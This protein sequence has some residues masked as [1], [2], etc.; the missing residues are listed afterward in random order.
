MS[1]RHCRLKTKCNFYCVVVVLENNARRPER[2]SH[3]LVHIKTSGILF[4]VDKKPSVCLIYPIQRHWRFLNYCRNHVKAINAKTISMIHQNH[5]IS[6][7][8]SHL[9]HKYLSLHLCLFS[10]FQHWPNISYIQWDFVR[11]EGFSCSANGSAIFGIILLTNAQ[12]QQNSSLQPGR[13]PW[14]WV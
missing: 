6:S 3:V 9:R 4:A 7:Q 12:N 2:P 1:K 11:I 14:A 13:L 5:K 10:F 8:I